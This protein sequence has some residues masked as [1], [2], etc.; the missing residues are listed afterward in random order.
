MAGSYSIKWEW[1]LAVTFWIA[2]NWI[3]A[4]SDGYIK[5]FCT[6]QDTVKAICLILKI[7]GP[8]RE[9]YVRWCEYS[10][11]SVIMVE[12]W[13][14]V[15]FPNDLSTLVF[16]C[17][18]RWPGGESVEAGILANLRDQQKWATLFGGFERN[19]EDSIWCLDQCRVWSGKIW[20]NKFFPLG[21]WVP[22]G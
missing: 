13:K 3:F 2:Y 5:I 19:N 1:Y 14:N 11:L 18:R 22:R 9:D 12:V 8:L 10:L 15:A 17:T 20:Y 21:V 4:L 16:L 6:L 7:I